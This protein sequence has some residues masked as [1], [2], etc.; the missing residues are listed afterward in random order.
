MSVYKPNHQWVAFLFV[1]AMLPF[2]ALGI[3]VGIVWRS[4]EVGI[5]AF[6]KFIDWI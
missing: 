5:E 2:V 4:I 3:A 6:D 1:I